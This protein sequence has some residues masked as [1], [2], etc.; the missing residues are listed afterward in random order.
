MFFRVVFVF[1]CST[2]LRKLKDMSPMWSKRSFLDSNTNARHVLS[3][4]VSVFE[5][6]PSTFCTRIALKLA[7]PFHVEWMDNYLRF[8]ATTE[9]KKQIFFVTINPE[10]FV[11]LIEND[12]IIPNLLIMHIGCIYVS[13]RKI[14]GSNGMPILSS[15][16]YM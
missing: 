5:C 3:F 7:I 11:F 1:F 10:T 9:K 12:T 8:R 6:F 2:H 4:K 14:T 13:I 15:S 16:T